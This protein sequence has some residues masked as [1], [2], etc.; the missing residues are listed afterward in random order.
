MR[1]KMS[2]LPIKSAK[3]P[4]ELVKM[5]MNS[6]LCR[7]ES[8]NLEQNAQKSL[9]FEGFFLFFL[10]NSSKYTR[11]CLKLCAF[12]LLTN[13]ARCGI[14]EAGFFGPKTAVR[15]RFSDPHTPYANFLLLLATFIWRHIFPQLTTPIWPIG[16][17]KIFREKFS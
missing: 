17:S 5:T 4:S 13:A 8:R 6:R 2:Q 7:R 15:A 16:K 9:T 3:S 1:A 11:F 14:I 10:H 12:C